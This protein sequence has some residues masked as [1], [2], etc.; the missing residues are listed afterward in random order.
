MD[1][2]LHLK[3]W[4]IIRA[5]NVQKHRWCEAVLR[6]WMKVDGQVHTLVALPWGKKPRFPFLANRLFVRL[7]GRHLVCCSVVCVI[8]VLN[9]IS[10]SRRSTF[11]SLRNVLNEDLLFLYQPTTWYHNTVPRLKGKIFTL[12]FLKQPVTVLLR[13]LKFSLSNLGHGAGYLLIFFSAFVRPENRLNRI[14]RGRTQHFHILCSELFT[15]IL[16]FGAA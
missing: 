14:H 16:L 1:G 6:H 12:Y 13:V 11:H 4:S 10:L 7:I 2:N 5:R 9:F 3:V 15:A 8:H